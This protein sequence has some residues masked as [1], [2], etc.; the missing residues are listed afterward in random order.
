MNADDPVAVYHEA[1]VHG[2]VGTRAHLEKL[3]VQSIRAFW[4]EARQQSDRIFG[5]TIHG[6]VPG[7]QFPAFSVTGSVCDLG[8]IHCDKKYLKGMIPAISPA[9]LDAG[10][11]DLWSRGGNGALVSGGSTREGIVEMRGYYPVLASI[12]KE[13]GL[14]L[15]LHTGLID[16]SDAALLRN[17][18]IDVVSL[19]LVGDDETIREIY[20]LHKTVDDYKRVL[21]G[22]MNVGFTREQL[23]PHVCIGLHKGD[24]RG[25]YHVLDYLKVLDPAIIVF[26]IIIP[27]KGGVSADGMRHG[28]KFVP[29]AEV[30]NVI[31]T[32]RALYP[33]ARLSLGCMRPG[34][35]NRPEYDLAAFNAGITSIAL[36]S[37]PFRTVLEGRGY[38]LEEHETC[39]A[40]FP[41]A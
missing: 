36:P 12:K 13:T 8:C 14:R 17:T 18:G 4:D 30:S 41:G 22:F 35:S 2:A 20:G 6:Y 16:A 23:V 34:G 15:N 33:E 11:R 37:K 29:S 38:A 28:F 39:C 26:I 3:D 24:V 19:D 9:T 32:A 21:A 40:L 10:L 7:S 31:A 25:E 27:P 1:T 5:K